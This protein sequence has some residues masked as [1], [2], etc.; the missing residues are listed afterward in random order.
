MVFFNI[1]MVE[2][3]I[4]SFAKI[5]ASLTVI[6]AFFSNYVFNILYEMALYD[7]YP[8]WYQYIG[9]YIILFGIGFLQQDEKKNN[10]R[11]A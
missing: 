11:R 5:G 2:C 7:N 8:G 4:R 10:E 1:K 9:S 6:V 3:K